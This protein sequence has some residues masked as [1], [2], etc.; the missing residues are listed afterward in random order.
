MAT[1]TSK[2]SSR[3]SKPSSSSKSQSCS[4]SSSGLPS[5]VAMVELKSRILAA[6]A[7][8]SD[9]DTHQIAIDD[10]E[11]II[12][13]LPAEGVPLLLSALIHDPAL[14]S[15]SPQDAPGSKHPSFLIVRRESL[16][17]LALLCAVHTDAASA[18]L[19][20]IMAHIAR[21]IKDSASD[22]SV[23]DACRDA[24]GSLAAL[25]LRPWVAAAAAP[26]DSAAGGGGIGGS[27]SMVALFVKPLFDAMGEQNKA[28][29][30]GAAMC[31]AKVVECAGVNDDGGEG[32]EGRVAAAAGT[33]FQRLC[34]RICK[35][36][37]GQ[38]F[39][40]KGAL[41]TVVSSLAQVCL[42]ILLVSW[43]TR[44]SEGNQI[45]LGW[46]KQNAYHFVFQVGAIHLQSM[47]QLLQIVRECLESSEWATRKA[48]ADTLCVLASHSSHLLGDGAAA[49][50]TALDACRFDKVYFLLMHRSQNIYGRRSKDK[51]RMEHQET[52]K[53]RAECSGIFKLILLFQFLLVP[54][55]WPADSRNSDLTD[56]EEKAT[57][58][59][60]DSNKRS[61]TMKNSSPGTSPSENDSVSR[62]KGT[63]LPEKAVVL[64][65]KKVP[66]LT[67]KELNPEFFQKLEK[68]S[69]DLPV[70]VVLPRK[71]LQ[72]S[73]SQCEE[74]PEAIYS[75]SMET[76]KHNGATLQLS[77]DIHGH[78]NANYH[79]AEKRLGVHNNVQDSDY[80][81]RERWTEQR[82]IR[83]KESKAE[84][85]DVD[86]RTEVCQ[87]DLSP[88]C[89]N[90]PRSDAHTE[91]LFMSNKANWSAIQ[92]QLAQLE[93]KQIS[94]MNMLQDFM[95]GSHDSMVTLEN[96][97]RGLERVV[98]EMAR[99]LAI[100]P[101]RRGG[102]MMQGFDKSPGRSSGKYNGLHDCSNSK[103]GRDSDGRF[104]FP[105]RFLSSESMVS[106]V[107]RRGSPWRSESETWDYHGASRNG[108]VNSRKGFNAVPVDG[109]VG[110]S[111]HD[112]DPVG[113]R[114]AWDKGPGPFR[115]GEGPSARSV[116]QAS[117]D[118]ATLE[119]IRVAGEDNV[120]SITAARVTVP[121]LDAEGIA[122]DNLG[123]DKG[124]LWASWTRAMDS[125]YVGDVDSAYA[126]ILSAGED[127]LLVKLMDK[128]G[129]VFDQLSN[130]IASEVFRAI[131]QFVLEESLFDIALSWLQQ[132]LL[133]IYKYLFDCV[134]LI[135]YYNIFYNI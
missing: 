59:R 132:V 79:N 4:S 36:L 82:G 93:R 35:L 97:V 9:R 57:H 111:E 121:E 120:T 124:P 50:I 110:R 1:S 48:A 87:K 100:K 30:G 90:V 47:L 67:D 41:L 33:M 103:F 76:P 88:G 70:E 74:G 130:E 71:C 106:G 127:L 116:W 117:K 78:N 96:R 91:G 131:G 58:K 119:A 14:P 20:K 126:E 99:D 8:L 43:R 102:N 26:D 62:G 29:Q 49:T 128:S 64:L 122:D 94:L 39:L 37:G 69:D 81:P 27:S 6:L 95:G 84:D 92:R 129:P 65:K 114:W 17:L 54:F 51:E 75:D 55:F 2:P 107:R 11:K 44:V 98:D 85:F 108:V 118:E 53:A 113:G 16:R 125:L 73:H 135:L 77:A 34:P 104:P 38:S 72:S 13:A 15:P 109:R 123:L 31:L 52:K 32:E 45:R 18:H 40:A 42:R 115:L 10:V 21:R 68:S 3:L 56:S 66:S 46:S 28:V 101:G 80:F 134:S 63:N 7:K 133:L 24:A 60:S 89:L 5:H 19:S 105:E 61:E 23:R 12:R 112:A 25:Y 22:S 83:A 86:D